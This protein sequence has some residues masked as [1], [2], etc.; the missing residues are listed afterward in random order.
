MKTAILY[1]S[2]HHGNTRK[3]CR[4][5]A[6]T[7]PDVMLVDVI[8]DGIPDLKNFDRI[9]LASGIYAGK[10][11][12]ELLTAAATCLREKKPVF[13]ILTSSLCR[14]SFFKALQEAVEKSGSTVI[15]KYQCQGY[16]T[17]GPFKLVGGVSKGHP[18]K[19]DIAGAVAFYKG[20]PAEA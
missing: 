10:P 11:G 20:L 19:S 7:D 17:F 18:D 3:L 13:L 12:K 8:N 1:Y 4:A 5:I 16:D 6:A 15:G 2:K 14:D 9:G